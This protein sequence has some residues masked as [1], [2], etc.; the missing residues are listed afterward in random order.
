[1]SLL[2]VQ[3]DPTRFQGIDE[4]F[5]F[6]AYPANILV[7]VS[8]AEGLCTFVSPS[9]TTYTGRERSKE[10]G[11]GWLDLVHA[12]DREV[13]MQGLAEA[14]HSQQPFRLMFRYLRED[15]VFRWFVA[16]GMPHSTPAGEFIGHLSLCFDVTPYQ[17]GEAQMECSIQNVFP[18]LKQTRLMAVVLDIH[19]RVQF[20]NGG[21][22][23]LLKCGGAAL[24]NC[25]LFERHLAPNDRGLLERLYPGGTQSA[26]F[27]VE[28][29]SELLTSDNES[30][31][32][33]WH[34][35]VWREY[36]G[37]VRGAM[38]IGDDVTALHREEEQ[39]SLYIKAFEATDHAIVV[40]NTLGSII[41]VNRAF[42]HLT[43]YSRDEALGSNPRI[44]QSGRHDDAFYRQMWATLLETGHWHGDIWDR[45]KD[46]G[47]YPKYLSISAIRNSSGQSTNYVGIF[48]DNS[49]R[50]TVEERLDH[51][52]HY[53][54]LTG[55]PNRCLLLDRLEQAIE[56]GIR[57]GSKV[58][59]LYIDL[60][61]FKLVND[62][63]GHS[64]GDL[65]LKAVAQRMKASV[66]SVDTVARLGGDE[67]VVLVPDTDGADDIR[68]IAEKLVEALT[69]PYDIEGHRAT[70]TPSIGI[71]IYPDDASDWK[72]LM[73][74]SDA[75]M[76]KAKQSGRGNFKFFHEVTPSD[77]AA[78]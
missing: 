68:V 17:E 64:A 54:T 77:K 25:S 32:I 53:D 46:G 5:H 27:P 65:L 45:R 19:G 43:G 63:Y 14:L 49:E 6:L 60:D 70:S 4:N 55:A 67:F 41:S 18:L 47:I 13:L 78:G 40:T 39:T 74:H 44:L 30:R 12:G 31:H 21:L 16:Q 8:N 72:E 22:C 11:D 1:M 48:Y 73:K 42:T 2:G 7:W 34:A 37:R 66:R 52:A 3:P 29:Q 76:Y 71:S 61:H 28:F 23:R 56:R 59:L 62:T 10:L 38:L 26:H 36:S 9:W 24:A 50:K 75:A 58:A 33:S 51:L 35:I 15:G 57:L 69:P 20:S